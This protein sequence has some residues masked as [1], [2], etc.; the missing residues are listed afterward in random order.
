ML[1]SIPDEQKDDT[2]RLLQLLIYSDEPLDLEEAVDALAVDLTAEPYF[3]PEYRT[4]VPT[5]IIIS[6]TSLVMIE[7]VDI[8]SP[9]NYRQ[10]LQLAHFSVQQYLK[11]DQVDPG[12]KHFLSETHAKASNA[13]LCLAYCFD[14]D[15]YGIEDDGLDYDD[16]YLKQRPFTNTAARIWTQYAVQVKAQDNKLLALIK[17]FLFSDKRERARLNWLRMKDSEDQLI[18]NREWYTEWFRASPEKLVPLTIASACGLYHSV[19][20]LLLCNTDPNVFCPV[21]GS[22]LYAASYGGHE[23]IVRLLLYHGARP[24][25]R[26]GRVELSIAISSPI[27]TKR[28]E[29]FQALLQYVVDVNVCDEVV[30]LPLV[31]AAAHGDRRIVDTLLQK[32][33]QVEA[34]DNQ[35]RKALQAAA[36][37]GDD[38][39]VRKLLE[40]N[41]D[42]NSSGKPNGSALI[43]ACYWGHE[44]VVRT[45]LKNG[46]N[47][48]NQSGQYHYKTA[49]D[50]ACHLGQEVIFRLLIKHVGE[51]SLHFDEGSL[52]KCLIS[53][54]NGGHDK[55]VKL[56]LEH[57]VNVN[58]PHISFGSPLLT[59]S[60]YGHEEVVRL[61]LDHGADV[62]QAWQS[63]NRSNV[64]AL[65]LA[66]KE[67]HEGLVE[68]LLDHGADVNAQG[69]D[70]DTALMLVC[71]R[72]YERLVELL[73]ARGA[74]I[75][76]V[77]EA[78]GTA[79]ILACMQRRESVVK[80]LLAHEADLDQ[81]EVSSRSFHNASV[82][83]TPLLHIIAMAKP[84]RDGRLSGSQA[85]WLRIL[86][87]L[88]A[89]GADVNKADDQGQTPLH[90]A[91]VS[92]SPN[93]TTTLIEA[94]ALLDQ[95]D[96]DGQTPLSE[97]AK[98]KF[99]GST[100]VLLNAGARTDMQDC[101]GR[102]ALHH[103]AEHGWLEICTILVEAGAKLDVLDSQGLTPL[104][105]AEQ[106][107]HTEVVTFLL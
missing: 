53:A 106:E 48:S 100:E 96:G 33:A 22:A 31:Q 19:E 46:A 98:C 5:E 38:E 51:N 69:G 50:A 103:A 57:E 80:I 76:Q 34:I 24:N 89:A 13:R 40:H 67:G 78:Y 81:A 10:V 83:R 52:D 41:A 16:E 90:Y 72:S 104:Q 35:E 65:Y 43:S 102:T 7:R 62:H 21:W 36:V 94:G 70:L 59:A 27:S 99:K 44:Q 58:V 64:R 91:A 42:V 32:G 14:L 88:V 101:D 82:S 37:Y 28:L 49:L 84:L 73:L 93:L 54:C 63:R 56:L 15:R 66:C 45:L 86:E 11:S 3:E 23:D 20:S 74:N 75:N 68:L 95:V 9:D 25:M 87:K 30:G 6:C 97:A 77:G 1:Q 26:A 4:P 92:G 71:D 85:A 17:D 55:I 8:L 12:W 18:P 29:I 47:I 79:L 2:I 105:L 61:L 39:I 60:E 107:D